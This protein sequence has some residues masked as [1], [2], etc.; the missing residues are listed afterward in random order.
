MNRKTSLIVMIG[1]AA[2]IAA[3][4]SAKEYYVGEPITQ[5]ALQLVPHYLTDIEMAPMPAG[6]DMAK[7]AIHLEIDIHATKDDKHGFAE[8]AWVPYLGVQYTIEK[9]GSSFKKR[10]RLYP[11][12]AGD[13]PHYAS[14]L[15]LSGEGDYKVSFHVSPP[16]TNGFLRHVDAATGVPDWWKPFDVQWTFHYPAKQNQG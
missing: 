2:I 9:V 1:A 12:T 13:G 4:V 5:N 6:M 11:M 15:Q 14:N 3:P 7:S 16:S 10:G 8:D